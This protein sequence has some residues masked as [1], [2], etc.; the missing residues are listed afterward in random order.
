MA[1]GDLAL[2]VGAEEQRPRAARASARGGAAAAASAGPPTAGRRRRARP[3]VRRRSRPAA[4]R[5]RRRSGSAARPPRRRPAPPSWSSGPR[6][7][8]PN[9]GSRIDS[10]AARGPSR[11]RRMSSGAP[12][13]QP[14]QHL[15][16][17]LVRRQRLLVEAPVE[18][19]RAVAVRHRGDLGRE[20]RLADPRV[21]GEQD[22]RPLP[23]GRVPPGALEVRE[24]DAA[25]DQPVPFHRGGER[26]RPRSG[27]QR[28][29][30]RYGPRR[31]TS[32]RAH[33]GGH[34]RRPSSPP[35]R[36]SCPAPRAAAT[37][38]P[39][40]PAAPRPGCPPPR[41]PP[42]G[43]D[44]RT[45]GTAPPRS[46]PARLVR[47]R[48]VH[49]RP[50]AGPPRPASPA[51]AGAT[52]P[53]HAAARPPSRPRRRA[54][55]SAGRWRARH[56]HAPPR[57]CG[58]PPP[59]RLGFDDRRSRDVS[60]STATSTVQ[61]QAQL[62]APRQHAVAQR[63]PQLRQQRA[64]R[65]VGRGGRAFGPQGVDELVARAAATT[66]E[67]QVGEEQAPL[68]PRESRVQSSAR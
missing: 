17:R 50:G 66:I 16:H 55:T 10:S 63:A 37:A 41:G 44:V 54:G 64:Q 51:R 6:A 24:L 31:A 39:R 67:D 43:A 60:M 56:G 45:P 12:A 27:L 7:A 2:A 4:R 57:A 49:A 3:G 25:P 11:S 68:P 52:S 26:R 32:A 8:A 36:A 53:A 35:G 62:A 46:P 20:P 13:D 21:A 40:T 47:L 30:R 19:R 58:R 15:H 29:R 61:P 65:G 48:P 9:S 59:S 22:E 14:A 18:H 42:S 34:A 5:R 38:T 28:H 23:V 33:R 1:V